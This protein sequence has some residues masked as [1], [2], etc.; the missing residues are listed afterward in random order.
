MAANYAATA[1]RSNI[2]Y[3]AAQYFKA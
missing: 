1:K 3:T 2:T